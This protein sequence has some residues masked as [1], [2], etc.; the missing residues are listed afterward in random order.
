LG[1]QKLIK[2]IGIVLAALVVGGVAMGI[3]LVDKMKNITPDA[4]FTPPASVPPPLT[5]EPNGSE[6]GTYEYDSDIINIL[7]LGIDT[8]EERQEWG[9]GYRTDAMM[10]VSINRIS[11]KISM[12]SIPRD[13]YANVD[14][15]DENGEVVQTYQSKINTAFGKGGNDVKNRF[16]NSVSAVETFLAEGGAPVLINNYIGVDMEGFGRI[17]DSLGGIPVTLEMNVPNIGQKGESVVL[18]GE[19]ALE[20]VRERSAFLTADI[21]RAQNQQS[22]IKGMAQ[23]VNELGAVQTA[24]RL[25]DEFLSFVE[26]D[27]NMDQILALANMFSELDMEDMNRYILP[28]SPKDIMTGAGTQ[29]FW[30]VD[31]EKARPE[32]VKMFYVKIGN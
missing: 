1:R 14:T 12:L 13:S 30:I 25:Y 19:Q 21:A 15:L 16:K 8:D 26:T 3:L 28:G 6:A 31:F 24:T 4:A 18:N 17:A 20:F 10:I 5:L 27:L 11:H 29:N 7:L 22:F 9:W 2:I 23:R 32:L